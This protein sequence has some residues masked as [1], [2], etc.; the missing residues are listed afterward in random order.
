[1]ANLSTNVVKFQAED[2]LFIHSDLVAD[3]AEDIL[4]EIY[5]SG[6]SDF[7]NIVYEA[8]EYQTASKPISTSTSNVFR[9]AI[10][11][12]DGRIINLN[13]QNWNCTIV[14]YCVASEHERHA[15]PK[16]TDN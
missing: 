6:V 15:P 14:V 3:G 10:T 5:T 16:K 4:Q 2:A 13:G 8:R 11:D 12:E 1:M 7:S 9:F